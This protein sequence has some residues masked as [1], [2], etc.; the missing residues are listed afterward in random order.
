M[1]LF[2]RQRCIKRSRGGTGSTTSATAGGGE[3]GPQREGETR[4]KKDGGEEVTH[5]MSRKDEGEGV[6]RR[7]TRR[8]S[9]MNHEMHN[10]LPRLSLFEIHINNSNKVQVKQVSVFQIKVS[11]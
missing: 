11:S 10:Q 7:L 6:T 1:G 8:F 2:E 4:N 3:I 5:Q 9:I